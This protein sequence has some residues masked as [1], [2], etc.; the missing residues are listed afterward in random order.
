MITAKGG[1]GT[2]A[3]E[4]VGA[5]GKFCVEVRLI[6]D[7]Q[8]SITLVPLDARGCP[9]RSTVVSLRHKTAPSADAG[10]T[11]ITNVAKKSPIASSE[12]PDS[13]GILRNLNDGDTKSWAKFSFWD[14]DLGSSC[15][16]ATWIRIDFG[17]LYTVS[18]LKIFWAPGA[19]SD[20]ATCYTVLLSKKD[21]PADPNP[22]SSDW[23]V[24]AQES[25]APGGTQTIAINPETA[26]SAALLMYE[27]ASTGLT[28]TFKIAEFEVYGQDPNAVPPPPP[29]SCK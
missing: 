16:A 5:D 22:S 24:V 28:E 21:S 26:K 19:G 4:A 29:D 23:V 9:G 18:K 25:S 17:K 20:Y 14:F 11:T 6:E 12:P 10:V 3:P 27:N 13:S 7:A 1:A 8:N 2:A 15:D